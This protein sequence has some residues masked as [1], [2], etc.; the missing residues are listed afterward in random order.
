MSTC[1]LTG[2]LLGSLGLERT[3]MAIGISTELTSTVA[4]LKLRPRLVV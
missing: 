2:E 3:Y 4:C 1:R